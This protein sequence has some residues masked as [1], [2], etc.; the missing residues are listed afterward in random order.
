MT[1]PRSYTSRN[2]VIRQVIRLLDRLL[3]LTSRRKP[4]SEWPRPDDRQPA[5][6]LVCNQSHLGDAILATAALPALRRAFPRAEIG[7]LVH[8]AS[9]V[10]FSGMAEVSRIHTFEHTLLNRRKESI[11]RTLWRHW[12]SRRVAIQ[13]IRA[14]RYDMAIDLYH[15]FPNSIP[16]LRATRIP[17]CAGWTSG[18]F[19]PWLN[20]ALDDVDAPMYILDRHALLLETVRP[21]FGMRSALDRPML[22]I[23]DASR[24]E[25]LELAGQH[26]LTGDFIVLHIGAHATL[27]RWPSEKW[28]ELAK[29]LRERGHA[30]VLLGLGQADDAIAGELAIACPGVVNLSSQLSWNGLLAAVSQCSLLVSHD[31][32]AAHLGAAFERP[33]ICLSAGINDAQ[34]WLRPSRKSLV[35]MKPVPCAPCFRSRGCASMEC[36][37]SIETHAVLHA[38]GQLLEGNRSEDTQ[39]TGSST[40]PYFIASKPSQQPGITGSQRLLPNQGKD[41][42]RDIATRKQGTDQ[43]EPDSTQRIPGE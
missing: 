22:G 2:P 21:G 9:A 41:N 13:S 4:L 19:G 25:W 26:G 34:V 28:L 39:F 10:V 16:L 31:S 3:G 17:Y 33:R 38:C 15:Y 27:R 32:A 37:R 6:I 30:V 35:L 42:F 20:L 29:G 12:Q 40:S 43:G 11:S 23:S 18:G 8:P 7:V 1:P 14:A 5:R 36:I 24:H